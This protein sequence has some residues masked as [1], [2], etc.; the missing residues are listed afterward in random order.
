MV[1]EERVSSWS[2]SIQPISIQTMLYC[3]STYAE[4]HCIQTFGDVFQNNQGFILTLR[5]IFCAV[6]GNNLGFLSYPGKFSVLLN[7]LNFFIMDCTVDLGI[8]DQ[9]EI[10]L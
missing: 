7:C 10:M 2:L 4:T 1:C 9:F 6:L 8:A 5:H 3:G